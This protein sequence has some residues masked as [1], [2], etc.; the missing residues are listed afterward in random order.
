VLAGAFGPAAPSLRGLR[1]DVGYRVT[2]WVA[3]HRQMITNSPA[4]LD[5]GDRVQLL[6]PALVTCLSAPIMMGETFVG[7]LTLY[8]SQPNAFD[9]ATGRMVQMVTP[10]IARAIHAAAQSSLTK[11]S[12]GPSGQPQASARDLR[13]VSNR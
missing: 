8:A 4:A 2:G 3:A 5:L 6:K 10:H 9:E 12:V 7:V 11:D 13:L 1:V